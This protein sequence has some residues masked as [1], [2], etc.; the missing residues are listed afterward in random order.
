MK[1]LHVALIL[2]LALG[3]G[4][5][6]LLSGPSA[7]APGPVETESD[8][9]PAPPAAGALDLPLA[10]A[11]AGIESRETVEPLAAAA[12]AP[13]APVYGAPVPEGE[14]FLAR[15]VEAESKKPIPFA[16][17]LFV[18]VGNL[19]QEAI[20]ARMAE[21]RDVDA[22]IEALAVRYRAGADGTVRLPLPTREVWAAARKDPWFGMSMETGVPRDGLTIECQLSQSVAARVRDER[23]RP[24]AGIPVDLRVQDDDRSNRVISIVTGE[25]GLARIRRLELFLRDAPSTRGWSLAIGGF[26]GVTVAQEF[27][28]ASP[29]AEPLE[30]LLPAC[31]QVEVRVTGLSGAPWADPAMVDL[32]AI[33]PGATEM[34]ERFRDRDGMNFTFLKEGSARVVPVGLGLHFR[35][36]VMRPDGSLVGEA[37][38][39]GPVSAGETA[40]I[41]VA[42][43]GGSSFVTGRVLGADGKPAAGERFELRLE[44]TGAEGGNSM[45]GH[46]LRT[47]AAGRFRFHVEE[48]VLP[49]G[50]K[51]KLTVRQRARGSSAPTASADLSWSLPPGESDLGD[52]L[53]GMA[54]LVAAGI[55]VDE[56]GEPVANAHVVLQ[57]KKHYGAGHA[58]FYWNWIEGGEA[59]TQADGLFALHAAAGDGEYQVS[60]LSSDLWCDGVTVRPGATGL[61]LVLRRGGSLAGKLL[62]DEGIE[63]TDLIVDL[64][65]PD[66]Q[67]DPFNRNSTQVQHD[68]AFSVPVLRPGTYGLSLRAAST[69]HVYLELPGFT[70]TAGEACADP[71]LNP[72]DARGLIR[73]ILLRV[74]D[75]DGNSV[76]R[77]SVFVIRPNGETD[78]FYGHEAQLRIPLADAQADLVVQSDGF[79]RARLTGVSGDQTVTLQRAPRVRIQVTNPEAIPAGFELMLRLDPSADRELRIWSDS[80]ATMGADGWADCAATAIG[81]CS[82]NAV[83]MMRTENGTRGWGIPTGLGEIQVRDTGTPQ[84]IQLTLLE[85]EIAKTVE[86]LRQND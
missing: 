81:P 10:P 40:L 4:A 44:T 23:G 36:R 78:N 16:E 32:R 29:P 46:D 59:F 51:R 73:G 17:I 75:A 28:P 2:L 50:S 62:A 57:E 70:V 55:V 53:L 21:L 42:E 77:F 12:S 43:R 6:F 37:E 61:Q 7:P 67:P 13:A 58:E 85:E 38:G 56:A 39:P 8:A 3:A 20:Q 33:V 52:L 71:R 15:A 65:L 74:R 83:L 1:P 31:G 47:D 86:R 60:C 69:G 27:D 5:W 18:D 76:E 35:A 82:V 68:G 48:P 63:L 19:D 24:Q 34:D 11:A 14:G 80:N 54:P 26:L 9:A 84:T 66:A 22:L 72:L 30:L 49:E 41:A 79:L 25:D 64:N 45:R